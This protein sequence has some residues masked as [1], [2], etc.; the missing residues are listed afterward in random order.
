MSDFEE[1]A[2]T[3][4]HLK[5]PDSKAKIRK[6]DQSMSNAVGGLTETLKLAPASL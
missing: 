3:S 2:K 4:A 5:V 6:V 1:K